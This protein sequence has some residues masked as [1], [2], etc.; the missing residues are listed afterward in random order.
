MLPEDRC[1]R[2]AK[3]LSPSEA[4]RRRVRAM[5][6][7]RVSAA[8]LLRE[9]SVSLAP[10]NRQQAAVW[11][12]VEG[13]L[14][15]RSKRLLD[16]L[17]EWL[18]PGED[19]AA[20]VAGRVR[21]R[22]TEP[23]GGSW[24]FGWLKWTASLALAA[25]L[26]QL[27][28]ALFIA[29]KTVAES[30]VILLPVQGSVSIF[31]S[32]FWQDIQGEVALQPGMQVRT[33]GGN[34][35][36][37]FRDDA[38][39]RLSPNTTLVVL[40]TSEHNDPAIDSIASVRLEEGSLWVQGLLPSAVRGFTVAFKDGFMSVNEGSVSLEQTQTDTQVMVWDRRV[41]VQ[42]GSENVSLVSGEQVAV[43]GNRPVLVKKIPATAFS[44]EWAEK[45]LAMDAVHRR[46]I[47]QLQH[48]R[49]A[50]L[51]GTLP[52]S[53]FYSVKRV[54]E[55]VDL[56]LSL[57]QTER[58]QKRIEHA[59]ARLNE[60]AAMLLSGE[61]PATV[62]TTLTEFKEE[63]AAVSNA[64]G[65][66][67]AQFL[68]RQ[69]VSDSLSQVSA[70]LPGDESYLLKETV[71]QAT[72]DLPSDIGD[73]QGVAHTLLLDD[74]QAFVADV[75]AGETSD[76]AQRWSELAA[77]WKTVGSGSTATPFVKKEVEAELQRL[78]SV[79]Q[80]QTKDGAVDEAVSKQVLADIALLA[81][82]E[83]VIATSRPKAVVLTPEQVESIAQSILGR[84][85]TYKMPRSRQNQLLL[86]ISALN[87]HDARGVILRAVY[88]DLPEDSSLR[89]PVRKEI[90]KLRW[91]NAG[92]DM[93][94]QE[95]SETPANG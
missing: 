1:H 10:S 75:Q 89:A 87:D 22:L 40:D 84:I 6:M 77:N 80:S 85:Y 27:S 56:L 63:L 18:T 46:H 35:S 53:S 30:K 14:P 71:L 43:V 51:A 73:G 60:A 24:T 21:S 52:T 61:D 68:L 12:R 9:A 70:S 4:Q 54:A 28:P 94:Q 69:S 33:N 29:P 32:G 95:T 17:H 66:L 19:L 20:A 44:S 15:V 37:L 88:R 16:Q 49:L 42:H 48:E 92:E 59:Q 91:Q 90:V 55:Q 76:I 23:Q 72:A 67:S 57:S 81:P 3:E 8:A 58:E 2:L 83:P 39:V 38:V 50:A 25:F 74:V 11:R 86:E 13:A 65:S 41:N 47:A 62:Q 45:N 82:Q 34:A 26:I 78:A 93:V 7:K 36:I 31:V 79:I 5:V 64:S